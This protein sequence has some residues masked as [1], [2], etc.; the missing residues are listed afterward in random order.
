MRE[1]HSPLHHILKGDRKCI[2]EVKGGGI[3]PFPLFSIKFW[4]KQP[5]NLSPTLPSSNL[6]F[7]LPQEIKSLPVHEMESFCL[8]AIWCLKKDITW[9][10][11]V[12]LVASESASPSKSPP[13]PAVAGPLSLEVLL[14]LLL[15]LVR[16]LLVVLWHCR[17]SLKQLELQ[18]DSTWQ[19][20]PSARLHQ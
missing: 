12:C 6:F 19:V 11:P 15:L 17:L 9:L 4:S 13:S 7:T 3:F 2:F 16:L 5:P 8:I 18:D 10:L 1:V 14:T 20:L